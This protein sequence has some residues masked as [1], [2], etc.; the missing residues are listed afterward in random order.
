MQEDMTWGTASTMHVIG[1]E[2][3]C[4][5]AGCGYYFFFFV[6]GYV[7]G[8]AGIGYLVAAQP[9][10]DTMF[11][12]SY[13]VLQSTDALCCPS[14]GVATVRYQWKG[15]TLVHLDQLHGDQPLQLP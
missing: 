3:S 5:S 7:V 4:P 12:V 9:L 14:G 13:K 11:A 8:K 15:N 1:A 6:N 10:G 2:R